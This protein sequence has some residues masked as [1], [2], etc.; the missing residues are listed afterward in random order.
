VS[1]YES[2][3]LYDNMALR[4]PFLDRT[5]L[6]DQQQ[7]ETFSRDKSLVL[8]WYEAGLEVM[9]SAIE[10]AG[11][12]RWTSTSGPSVLAENAP[13]HYVLHSPDMARAAKDQAL[14]DLKEQPSVKILVGL[15]G[16]L[17]EGKNLQSCNH[18]YLMELPSVRHVSCSH[19][20]LLTRTV[21]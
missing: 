17:D 20:R 5:L 10:A 15:I 6:R 18:M 9:V 3:S 14:S 16:A 13:G 11:Y 7:C 19:N 8:G 4:S 1:E 12:V 2:A 21:S